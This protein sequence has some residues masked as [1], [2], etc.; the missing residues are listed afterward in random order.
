MYISFFFHKH[1]SDFPTFCLSEKVLKEKNMIR[2]GKYFK[3]DHGF[4][5]DLKNREPH[6]GY[7]LYSESV[8]RRTYS[9]VTPDGHQENW[10]D[11]I[12]RVV[13]GVMIIRKNFA[14]SH[15][16]NDEQMMSRAHQ[17]A[18][19]MFE[20]KFLPGGRHLWAMGIFFHCLYL[21]LSNND[22]HSIH[23]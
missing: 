13:E 8:Y 10:A 20:M 5:C 3:F 14:P 16:W 11:T 21:S 23:L 17:M 2:A 9:R 7:G 4:V 19:M 22:R 18:N 1:L 12:I 6:F 15:V